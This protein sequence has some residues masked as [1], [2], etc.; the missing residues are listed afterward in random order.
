[1]NGSGTQKDFEIY[2]L[3]NELNQEKDKLKKATENT[4]SKTEYDLLN[5][6]FVF[7]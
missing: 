4:V 3:R 5:N 7:Q 2:N 1:M 6:K